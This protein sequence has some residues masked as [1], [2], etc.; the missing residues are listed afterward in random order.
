MEDLAWS[1]Q[2]SPTARAAARDTEAQRT[3]CLKVPLVAPVGLGVR[4]PVPR[5]PEA[6]TAG[7]MSTDGCEAA[8]GQQSASPHPQLPRP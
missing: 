8:R 7:L 6:F 2:S 5:G 3:M 4:P 1:P